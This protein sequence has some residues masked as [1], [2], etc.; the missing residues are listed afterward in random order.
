MKI[1]QLL[2]QRLKSFL[3]NEKMLRK[4]N[5]VSCGNLFVTVFAGDLKAT[6]TKIASG[7]YTGTRA[8]ARN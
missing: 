8:S 7:F 2:Q 3:F 6:L 4:P 5:T 1:N